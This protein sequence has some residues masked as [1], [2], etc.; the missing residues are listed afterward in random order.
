MRG[1]R[2]ERAAPP[3]GGWRLATAD[4]D[5]RSGGEGGINA[6]KAVIAGAIDDAIGIPDAGTRR[7]VTPQRLRE[8]L[9][10]RSP[11]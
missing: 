6:V 3:K 4:I 5:P 8:L 2:R 7:Q 9:R 1:R 10:D 11:H